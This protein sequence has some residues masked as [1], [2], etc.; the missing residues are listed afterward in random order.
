MHTDLRPCFKL[1]V[2][3]MEFFQCVEVQILDG[4][5]VGLHVI[6]AEIKEVNDSKMNAADFRRIVVDQ[7]DD[8]LHVRATDDQFLS[9][10]TLDPI[11]VHRFTEPIL[12]CIHGIDMTSDADGALCHQTFLAG[13]ATARVAQ[14]AADVMEDRVRDELFVCGILLRRRALHEMVRSRGQHRVQI[15]GCVRLE[16]LKTTELIKELAGDDENVF[17]VKCMQNEW[18]HRVR[19][20]NPTT[21]PALLRLLVDFDP[22]RAG[23]EPQIG[24]KKA[25]R[26]SAVSL[27]A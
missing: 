20:L 14:V 4:I 8:F 7:A 27:G 11:V 15:T 17:H 10:L 16:A 13:T 3:R 23:A 9:H 12:A 21:K 24:S 1:V 22:V 5:L 18:P 6:A 25:V 19:N 2:H 26:G